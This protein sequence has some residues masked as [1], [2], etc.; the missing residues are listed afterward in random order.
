MKQIEQ[1]RRQRLEEARRAKEEEDRLE[2][3]GWH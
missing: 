2:V 3:S 1:K